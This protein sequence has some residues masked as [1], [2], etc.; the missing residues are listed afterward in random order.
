MPLLSKQLHWQTWSAPPHH[1]KG[2]ET[3]TICHWQL[4]YVTKQ[5]G[6]ARVQLLFPLLCVQWDQCS[7]VSYTC[8]FRFAFPTAIVP[9]PKQYPLWH[10]L[11]EKKSFS[12]VALFLPFP[13]LCLFLF[14]P[15]HILWK[16][17]GEA[18]VSIAAKC[19]C[20][21]FSVWVACWPDRQVRSHCCS[22]LHGMLFWILH[23]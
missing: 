18:F 10:S 2:E 1:G 14:L 11:K 21:A 6:T 19:M 13:L 8:T 12:A 5:T 3:D 22:S 17:Q 15:P 4:A 9:A 16:G 23:L 20:A 7:Q